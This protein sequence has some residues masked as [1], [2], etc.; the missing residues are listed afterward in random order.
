MYIQV[1]EN[2]VI[3]SEVFYVRVEDKDLDDIS[4]NNLL[5]YTISDTGDG[6]LKHFVIDPWT[7]V[8]TTN[9]SID[10]EMK[11]YY[12]L[13]IVVQDNPVSPFDSPCARAVDLEIQILDLNDNNPVCNFNETTI[14]LLENVFTPGDV[15]GMNE[16]I[17][18]LSV[19]CFD[20]DLGKGELPLV[21]QVAR[22][23]LHVQFVFRSQFSA[24]I[25][26]PVWEHW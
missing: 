6:I 18:D 11:S 21:S 4:G 23:I 1:T 15:F 19:S 25:H 2:I 26:D 8:I 17:L 9:H 14:P 13:T 24:E 10:R 22:I 5:S 16:L 12:Y 20:I 3:G 7:G